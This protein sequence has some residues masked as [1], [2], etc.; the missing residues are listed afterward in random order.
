MIRDL[1]IHASL[2]TGCT[3]IQDHTQKSMSRPLLLLCL[4]I[5]F[6]VSLISF[7]SSE[8]LIDGLYPKLA[9]LLALNPSV[10]ITTDVLSERR[11][12]WTSDLQETFCAT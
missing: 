9:A 4:R 11:R 2:A 6:R 1:L 7:Q 10:V 12:K 8:H 5:M 3:L